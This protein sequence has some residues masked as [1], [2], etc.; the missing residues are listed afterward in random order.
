M[1]LL[2]EYETV[3]HSV[4]FQNTSNNPSA[5]NRTVEFVVNDGSV[6]SNPLSRDVEIIP[7]ND[8]PVLSTIELA[9]AFFTENGSPVGIT[10]NLAV[11]DID[12]TQIN[13]AKI[14]ISNGF[15]PGEDV[16]S[17]TSQFGIT[18]SFDPATGEL[19]LS[20]LAL[21][22]EYETVLHS[23]TFQNTSDNPSAVNRTVEFVVNDGLSLIHI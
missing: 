4:T 7:V 18:G 11:D 17:F 22:S 23:V 9:P 8:A 2:S 5:A 21:L 15:T 10:S 12:N 14:S 19:N 6:D 16:L 3:L 13:S 20:G 1:A